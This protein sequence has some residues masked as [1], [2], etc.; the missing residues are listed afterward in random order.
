M[1]GT[2]SAVAMVAE[3][4]GSYPTTSPY[5]A[6]ARIATSTSGAATSRKASRNSL[7]YQ[8]TGS[9]PAGRGTRSSL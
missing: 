7:I 6:E 4:P 8:G 5:T 9:R 1:T 3:R 2:S